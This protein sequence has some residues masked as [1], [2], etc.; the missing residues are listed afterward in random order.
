LVENGILG[1]VGAFLAM[2]LVTLATG[3]LSHVVFNSSFDVNGPTVVGLIVSVVLLAML[4]AAFVSWS[5]LSVR[6]LSVLRYE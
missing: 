1:A 4:T 3:I 2:L 6:P 5:A